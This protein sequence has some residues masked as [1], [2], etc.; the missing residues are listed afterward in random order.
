MPLIKQFV[1]PATPIFGGTLLLTLML[2][3]PALPR[4]LTVQH[5]IMTECALL[6]KTQKFLKWE[7][8]RA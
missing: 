7:V 1:M 6:A 5:A 2:V 8:P 4:M 3:K